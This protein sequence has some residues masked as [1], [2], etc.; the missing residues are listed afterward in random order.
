MLKMLR[1]TKLQLVPKNVQP[2]RE[3]LGG[4]VVFNFD[5]SDS[6]VEEASKTRKKENS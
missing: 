2:D 5:D 4:N 6:D 3:S 1:S